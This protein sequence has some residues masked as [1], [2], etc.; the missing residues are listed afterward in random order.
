MVRRPP[1]ALAWS[2]H[3]VGGCYQDLVWL[4]KMGLR[5]DNPTCTANNRNA[6]CTMASSDLIRSM[7]NNKYC[8][9]TN[10]NS[11]YNLLE[12]CTLV[13]LSTQAT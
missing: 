3:G 5:L 10:S 12:T 6:L 8:L 2:C 7:V 4:G 9:K 11:H 13:T 1:A